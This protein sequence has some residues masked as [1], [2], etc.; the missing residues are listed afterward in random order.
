MEHAEKYPIV[1]PPP[2]NDF[3]LEWSQSQSCFHIE[4]LEDAL[5]R[6]C[7]AFADNRQSDYIILLSGLSHRMASAA[8]DILREKEG[9]ASVAMREKRDRMFE[10]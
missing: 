3:V 2:K 10:L 9:K 1:A 4:Q 6:N 8:A 7:E 5:K